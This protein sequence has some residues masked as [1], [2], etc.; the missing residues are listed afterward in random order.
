MLAECRRP[1]DERLQQR[2]C[3][4]LREVDDSLA[5]SRRVPA[6]I[7]FFSAQPGQVSVVR[8]SPERRQE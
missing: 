6:A 3:R 2:H 4:V 5:G 1:L 8:D 7:G